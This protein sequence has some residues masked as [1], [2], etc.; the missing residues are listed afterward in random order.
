[1]VG[2]SRLLLRSATSSLTAIRG[3]LQINVQLLDSASAQDQ[4]NLDLATGSPEFEILHATDSLVGQWADDLTDL[5]PFVEKYRDQFDLDDISQAMWGRRHRRREDARCA[6]VLEHDAFLLQLRGFSLRTGLP[7]PD[8]YDDVIAACG[9]L[10]GAGYDDAFNINVGAGWAWEIEF[11]N[12]LKSLGGNVLN[13][14]NGPGWNTSEGLEAVNKIVEI[15][16]ACM[17]DAGRS[18]SID[19]A[20]AALRAGELPMAHDLGFACFT[21]G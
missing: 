2:S 18:Y 4:I 19:D 21:D 15:S 6:V 11:S 14:D 10:R 1:M 3:I 9:V 7:P 16:D 17:T 20:E 5:T 13:D 8:T 12:L